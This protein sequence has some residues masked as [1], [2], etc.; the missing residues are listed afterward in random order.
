LNVAN[1]VARGE[2]VYQWIKENYPNMRLVFSPEYVGANGGADVVYMFAETVDDSSTA[3]NATIIQV[4][5]AKYQL[6]GSENKAKGYLEDATNATAGI[7]VTRP[8]AVTRLTG[9]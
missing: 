8:W 6:L 4:V 1:P 2:T 5:P 9:I 7:I 3:T